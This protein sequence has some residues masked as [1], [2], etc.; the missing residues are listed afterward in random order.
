MPE[1][2]RREIIEDLVVRELKS[3]LFMTEEEDL[4]LET[5]F[6]DLGLTSL[7]LSEVKSVL[8]STLDCEIQTTV[9]FRRPT[10]EQLI[11]HLTD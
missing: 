6:F 11:D 8:E 5:G 2:E 4:P 9:L 3:A 1:H 10:P 7:K